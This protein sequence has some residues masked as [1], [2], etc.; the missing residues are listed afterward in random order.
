M[1]T[2]LVDIFIMPIIF[3]LIVSLFHNKRKLLSY[4]A[5]YSS[6]FLVI[7]QIV[8]W[9]EL[10]SLDVKK[11]MLPELKNELKSI[12]EYLRDLVICNLIFFSVLFGNYSRLIERQKF[13]F[14]IIASL[15]IAI[16]MTAVS[17]E[18]IFPDLKVI[19]NLLYLLLP[20][21][22]LYELPNI[23]GL[24]KANK[25]RVKKALIHYLKN[26]DRKREN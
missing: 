24:R 25:I 18:F 11:L 6:F 2:K 10:N 19:F 9:I 12:Q 20:A 17:F 13:G 1:I 23:T 14:F 16:L 15:Q 5:L 21:Y 7:I 8:Y 22:V 3:V 26:I 4:I